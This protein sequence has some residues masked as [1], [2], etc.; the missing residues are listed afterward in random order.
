M[1]ALLKRADGEVPFLLFT[2]FIQRYSLLSSR[3]TAHVSHVILN[4]W[5]SFHSAYF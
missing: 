1:R 2:A 4:E 3:L 5:L